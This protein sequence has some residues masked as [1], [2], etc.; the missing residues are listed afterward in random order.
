MDFIFSHDNENFLIKGLT[1]LEKLGHSFHMQHMWAKAQKTYFKLKSSNTEDIGSF[2]RC[3]TNDEKTG[4][5]AQL[6][7]IAETNKHFGDEIPKQLSEGIKRS[8]KA[9]KQ[10]ASTQD[11]GKGFDYGMNYDKGH[12]LSQQDNGK[13]FDYGMNYN[14]DQLLS[15]QNNGKGFDYGMNYDKGHPLS[16][17]DNGKGFDYGMNYNKDQPLSQQDNGKGFSR[18]DPRMD[19]SGGNICPTS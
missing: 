14:K 18:E 3:V 2:C 15:Q 5:L 19:N 6:S 7:M 4:V 11:N 16:L 1:T 8:G 9:L 13:G 10:V 12:P 17:Q